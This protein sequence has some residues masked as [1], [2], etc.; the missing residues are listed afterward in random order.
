MDRIRDSVRIR[1]LVFVSMFG[2]D[3]RSV[4]FTGLKLY[5]KDTLSLLTKPHRERQSDNKYTVNDSTFSTYLVINLGN[6]RPAEGPSHRM[7]PSLG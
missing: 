6:F 2:S 3:G 4:G 7:D 5:L 1:Y